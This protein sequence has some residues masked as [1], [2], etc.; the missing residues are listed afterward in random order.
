MTSLN[1][2][3]TLFGLTAP[4]GLKELYGRDFDGGGAAPASGGPINLLAF[5]GKSPAPIPPPY[6]ITYVISTISPSPLT[7]TSFNTAY[8]LNIAG[9]IGPQ[10]STTNDVDVRG[11]DVHPD[12]NVSVRVY[13]TRYSGYSQL[14]FWGNYLRVLEESVN[15]SENNTF[16]SRFE[17]L[18][19]YRYVTAADYFGAASV[20]SWYIPIPP[21]V[22]KIEFYYTK[23]NEVWKGFSITIE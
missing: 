8:T 17:P 1:T 23:T 4:H 19:G 10:V 14:R 13:D 11:I 16:N 2:V 6:G 5:T 21:T 18:Q 9:P 7:Y 12:D 3:S 20:V 15:R 22:T